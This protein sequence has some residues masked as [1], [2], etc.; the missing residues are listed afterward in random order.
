MVMSVLPLYYQIMQSIKGWIVNKEFAPGQQIPSEN[1]LAKSFGVSRLTVHQATSQLRREGFI[2]SRRGEG[3]FVTRDEQLLNSIGLEFSG[4]MDDLHFRRIVKTRVKS[5]EISKVVPARSIGE[6]L[7][8]AAGEEEVVRIRRVR[9]ERDGVF[10]YLVNY[11]PAE[12]GSNIREQELYERGLLDVLEHDLG[13][14]SNE[15]V[16]TIEAV[17]ADQEAAEKLEVPAGSPLLKVERIMYAKNKPVELY[18]CSYRGDLHKFIFRLKNV[19][20]RSG[21]RWVHAA[22]HP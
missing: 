17:M 22:D 5:V 2:T 6:K 16:Q 9:V 3:T 4:F 20:G 12:I 10:S 15:A 7:A 8:L 19:E 18:Q 1:D 11:L 14:I 13:I 21:S